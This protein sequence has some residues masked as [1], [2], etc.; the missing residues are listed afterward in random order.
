VYL[1]YTAFEVSAQNESTVQSL[2]VC[3]CCA[4]EITESISIKF[5]SGGEGL[6]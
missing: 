5:D 1:I 3:L 6:R 4:F 2:Q